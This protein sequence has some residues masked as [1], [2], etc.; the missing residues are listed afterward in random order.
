MSKFED[1]LKTYAKELGIEEA[2]L[3]QPTAVNPTVPGQHPG[4]GFDLATIVAQHPEMQPLLKQH[5]ELTTKVAQTSAI[6][7]KN[8]LKQAQQQLQP[9]QPQ[10]GNPAGAGQVAPS[11]TAPLH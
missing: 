6:I 10:P 9:Q 4:Q 8:I 5:Q 11:Q 3:T 1:N 7:A 2:V